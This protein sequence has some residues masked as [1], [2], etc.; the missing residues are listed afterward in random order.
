MWAEIAL[1]LKNL[2]LYFL[3]LKKQF[4]L[5]VFT[6][7]CTKIKKTQTKK[8]QKKEKMLQIGTKKSL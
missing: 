8:T 2:T 3:I 1:Q 6:F 5:E 7:I 4:K